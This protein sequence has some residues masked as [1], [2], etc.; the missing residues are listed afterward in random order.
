MVL[1]STGLN[2]AF[3]YLRE[4][5]GPAGRKAGAPCFGFQGTLEHLGAMKSAV[6]GSETARNAGI[7][8]DFDGFSWIFD[9][10]GLILERRSP[11]LMRFGPRKPKDMSPE[12]FALAAHGL[13]ARGREDIALV[14]RYGSSPDSRA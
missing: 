8:V 9:D 10:F 5:Y 4:D 14:A 13:D 6:F 7:L 2:E 11:T 12:D 3:T 1:A